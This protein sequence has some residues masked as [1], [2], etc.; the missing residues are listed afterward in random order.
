MKS[1]L[2]KRK[3]SGTLP[4]SI[5]HLKMAP[6]HR[7]ASLEKQQ[8]H[9]I[10]P[11]LSAVVAVLFHENNQL[12]IVF[13]RRSDYVGFH[14]GQI[15]FPGGRYEEH[16]GDLKVTAYRE[17]EEEIGIKKDHLEELGYLSDLYVPPSN[18]LVRT[19]VAY[20]TKRPVYKPDPREVKEV[21]EIEIAC[22]YKEEIVKWQHFPTFNNQQP[23][24][25]PCFDVNGTVIWGATAMILSELLDLLRD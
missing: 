12:K 8:H 20:A 14:S 18:F 23:T 16:D 6:E 21:I 22:F 17:L 9:P 24:Y 5:S 1:D 25:S 10:N 7:M 11:R 4:G 13:I 2:L 3:L 15:S 19:Y